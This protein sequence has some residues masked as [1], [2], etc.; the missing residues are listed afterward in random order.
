MKYIPFILYSLGSA[1]FL[2]GS[3]LSIW[4]MRR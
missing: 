1:L 4:L 3:L 2:G